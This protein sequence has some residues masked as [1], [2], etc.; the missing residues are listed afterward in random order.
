MAVDQSPPIDKAPLTPS[1][2]G[3]CVHTHDGPETISPHSKSAP[4]DVTTHRPVAWG[5]VYLAVLSAIIALGAALRLLGLDFGLP[6]HHHW[7]EGWIVDSAAGMLRR[8]D[9]MP[10]SYQYGAPLMRLTVAAY[11]IAQR[12]R[13]LPVELTPVAAQT[14]LYACARWVVALLSS[15]GTVAVYLAA[16]Y[17]SARV[18]QPCLAALAAALLY[19]ISSE[20]VMH[21]RYAVTDACLV[22]L[23]AWTLAFVAIYL[24]TRR[25]RWG[26]LSVLAA[27]TTC[28]FKMP[29]VVTSLIPM[30]ATLSLWV[31]PWRS[32]DRASR[33]KALFFAV[34]PVVATCY[35]LFNPHLV[36]RWGDAVRDL[37]GR[38]KQTRDGGFSS[39]YLR[40]PGLD[41]LSSAVW[42]VLAILPSRHVWMSLAISAVTIAGFVDSLRRRCVT[43]WI[44]AIYTVAL[45]LSVALPNRTFLLRNYIVVV[46]GMSL[47]FGWGI[48]FFDRML[49]A[50]LVRHDLVRR[51]A[52]ASCLLIAGFILIAIPIHDGISAWKLRKDPRVRAIEWIRAQDGGKAATVAVTP[53]VIGNSVLMSYPELRTALER[54]DIH[55]D[56]QIDSCPSLQSAPDYVVVASHRDTSKPPIHDPWEERWLFQECDGYDRTMMFAPNEYVVNLDAYPTWPGRVSAIVLRRASARP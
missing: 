36:D 29:G 53:S 48:A 54:D 49:R 7:D 11:L 20:L 9:N 38:Y 16:R 26:L 32:A 15:T 10:A 22:A 27:G 21:S 45:V 25:A 40:Q 56:R 43:V 47:G 51:L 30:L 42:A 31:G 41:H 34:A 35:L 5:R 12:M 44:A 4:F 46:P 8:C 55:F 37:V 13:G 19:A 18:A 14:T 52:L 24:D 3:F 28:A 17:A 1:G 50:R 23:T 6:Y 2:N 39:V 33:H